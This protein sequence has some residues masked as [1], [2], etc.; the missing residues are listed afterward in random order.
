[1][2]YKKDEIIFQEIFGYFIFGIGLNYN[3]ELFTERIQWW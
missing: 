3:M 1:M 2:W